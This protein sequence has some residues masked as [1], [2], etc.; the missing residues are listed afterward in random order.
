MI[1][2]NINVVI[3]T[4]GAKKW[5]NN[6]MSSRY[7]QRYLVTSKGLKILNDKVKNAPVEPQDIT[8]SQVPLAHNSTA[9]FILVSH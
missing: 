4:G 5:N 8:P 3:Q 1:K 9:L 2:D 6:V 7:L